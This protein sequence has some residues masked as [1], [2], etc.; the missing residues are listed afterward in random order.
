MAKAVRSAQGIED[1]KR[2][3]AEWYQANRDEAIAKRRAYYRA[4]RH[5]WQEKY[6]AQKIAGIRKDPTVARAWRLSAGT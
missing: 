4:N 5:R 1:R 3:A 6:E 2:R